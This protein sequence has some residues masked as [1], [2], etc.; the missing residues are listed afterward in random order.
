MQGDSFGDIDARTAMA[1]LR[2]MSEVGHKFI[3][4][5]SNDQRR[6]WAAILAEA[7]NEQVPRDPVGPAAQAAALQL[8]DDGIYDLGAGLPADQLEELRDYL[9]ECPVY[10]THVYESF[11]SA[12]RRSDHIPRAIGLGAEAFRFG[13]YAFPTLM[14]APHLL[15][16]L[17]QPRILDAATAFLGAAPTLYS[18]NIWWSFPGRYADI[19]YGQHFHRD[20][21]HGK[22]CTAFM[23]LTDVDMETGP[24][25]YLAGSN[26]FK[27]SKAVLEGNRWG[28]TAEELQTNDY[29]GPE[30]DEFYL[31][32]WKDHVRHLTGPAGSAF[33]TD[34]FGFHRGEEPVRAPRLALWARFSL[35]GAPPLHEKVS[36]TRLGDAYPTD[37]RRRYALR[38]LVEPD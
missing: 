13:A 4:S 22:V 3:N 2:S 20:W 26:N 8:E 19:K 23:Y 25:T 35:F 15:D 32:A 27:R 28:V 33:M 37:E 29:C 7:V 6:L 10:N 12:S 11:N 9:L 14:Q 24:H 36:R 1:F 38:G 30:P 5:L 18:V 21:D 34:T 31:D 17:L 16:F